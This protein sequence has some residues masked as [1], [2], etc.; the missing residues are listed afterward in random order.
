MKKLRIILISLLILTSVNQLRSQDL[1][2][3]INRIANIN[4]VQFE[5]QS[6]KY[7]NFKNFELLKK[8]SNIAQ[9]LK[10]IDNKNSVVVCYSSFALIDKNYNQIEK[11]FTKL[12]VENKKVTTLGGCL[13]DEEELPAL[14]YEYFTF[15]SKLPEN[16][17]NKIISKLDSI[18]IFNGNSNSL[19]HKIL[20]DKIV[21]E[22]LNQQIK[23]LA[24]QKYNQDALFYITNLNLETEKDLLKNAWLNYIDKTELSSEYLGFYYGTVEKLLELKDNEITNKILRKLTDNKEEWKYNKDNFEEVLSKYNLK[25]K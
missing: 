11:I 16:K 10:L 14:F 20:K 5:G 25:I 13:I 8:K 18:S 22:N 2:V 4:E 19:I 9:L 7:Q 23:Y 1:N 24:Y 15:E 3:I 17:K 21:S 12:L 6:G